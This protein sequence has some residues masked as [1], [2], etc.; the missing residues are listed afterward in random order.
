MSKTRNTSDLA[1]L[2]IVVAIRLMEFQIS[3]L[4][5]KISNQQSFRS[6]GFGLF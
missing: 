3:D 5:F 6:A 2:A 1:Q 4:R